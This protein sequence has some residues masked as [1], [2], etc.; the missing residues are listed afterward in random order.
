MK[1]RC[2]RLKKGSIIK[3]KCGVGK[4][5]DI[6]DDLIL[7]TPINEAYAKTIHKDEAELLAID[8]NE[9]QYDLPFDEIIEERNRILEEIKE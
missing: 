5:L 7:Y 2:C 3:T 9:I 8:G 6:R 4:V 1:V